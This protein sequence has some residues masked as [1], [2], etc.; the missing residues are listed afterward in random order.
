MTNKKAQLKI[1]EMAFVLV[2][3]VFLFILLMLFFAKF[4]ESKISDL[5]VEIRET[6]ITT[7]LRSIASLPELSCSELKTTSCIDKD[8]LDVFQSP[9]VR[10]RY[11]YIW[12]SAKISKLEVIEIFPSENNYI[13]YES[14]T[15][16]STVSYS[17]FISLCTSDKCKIGKL[18]ATI[19]V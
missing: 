5:S 1:Q 18:K 15:K 4:Q 2:A 9:A 19:K 3:V 12:D 7:M 8:K 11:S 17:T 16:E 13:I 6:R 10:E 14:Q